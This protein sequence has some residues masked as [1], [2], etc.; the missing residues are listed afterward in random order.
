MDDIIEKPVFFF[1]YKS[2]EMTRPGDMP[3]CDHG[4]AFL[5][6][7]LCL[8]DIDNKLVNTRREGIGG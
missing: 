7:Y 6:L 8:T 2:H 5:M 4:D 3:S 1:S